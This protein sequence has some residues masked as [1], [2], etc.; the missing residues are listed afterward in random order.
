MGFLAVTPGKDVEIRHYDSKAAETYILGAAVVLD[1]TPEVT[2]CGADPAAILGFAACAFGVEPYP[3]KTPVWLADSEKAR[4][5]ITGSS[6]GSAITTPT[7]A[8]RDNSYGLA[9]DGDGVWYLDISDTVNT[10]AYVHRIDAEQ[11][12]FEI[13][14]LAANRQPAP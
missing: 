14:I 12:R 1:G 8:H 2:E 3:T 13:S 6:D 5:W 10:R 11:L 9:V 4:F 7:E